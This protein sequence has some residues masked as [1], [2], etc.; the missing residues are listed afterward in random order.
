MRRTVAFRFLV[1]CAIVLVLYPQTAS[2]ARVLGIDVSTYQ[3][4]SIDW[5][6]VNSAGRVFAYARSSAGATIDDGTFAGNMSRGTDAGLL[7]GA[8]H[9][10]YPQYNS[11]QTEAAHFLAHSGS[12]IGPGYLR[13]V[14]D[15]EEAGGTVPVGASSLSAWVNAFISYVTANSPYGAQAEPLIYCNTNY[16]S[17]YLNSSVTSHDLWIANWNYSDAYAQNTANNPGTGVWGTAGINWSFWQYSDN[18]SVGGISPVDKD[19]ANGDINFVRSFLIGPPPPD[20]FERFDVNNTT[21][22]SGVANNGNYTWEAAKYSSTSAGTDAAAWNEGNFLRLAAGTDAGASNYTITANSNHTFAGMYLQTS[23]GGTVTVNGPGVLTTAS[24]DQGMYVDTSTQNLKI[25]AVIAGSSKLVWQGNGAGAGGSL[26]LLGD[27]TYTGGT[28]L[29]TGSGVNFNNDHSFGTGRITLGYT[30]GTATQFVMANDVATGPVT[31]ANAVTTKAGGT[32]VYVG[33]AAAPVTFSGNW[34]MPSGTSTLRIG[35]ASH[36]SSK[37]IISGV[38]SGSGG[39]L[40]KDG[41]G[42]LVLS[43]ANTYTGGTTITAGI[44]QLGDGGT[45]GKLST[46]GA[47]SNNGSL[48]FKQTDTVTQGTDFSGSAISGTGSLTQAGSGTLVL[49]AANTYNGKTIV[50][51]GTLSVSAEANLG[52]VPFSNVPDQLTINGGTFQA[53]AGFSISQTRGVTIGSSGATIRVLSGSLMAG[54]SITNTT[55]S[56]VTI[57]GGADFNPSGNNSTTFTNGK[58]YITGG[59][60]W[61]NGN[62]DNNSGAAPGSPVANFLTLDNGTYVNNGGHTLNA[63]K[64]ITLGPGGG[65]ID[66]TNGAMTYNGVITGAGALTKL[67]ANTLTLGGANIYA[68]GTNLNAGTITIAGASAKLG[69]GNVTVL[70]ATAGTSLVIQSGVTDAINNSALL[71]LAGGGTA[72]AADQG[73]ANLGAGINEI[74]GSLLL[75]GAAQAQ[76]LTYGS[77]S[78][79]A[80]VR[81]DEY[82]AGSGI[83]TVGL[84][85]DFNGDGSVDTR[86]FAAWRKSQ[87]TYGGSAGYDLWQSNF[88]R[89]SGSGSSGSLSQ[90]NVPEP[91]AMILGLLGVAA[92]AMLRSRRRNVS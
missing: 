53:T 60:R 79:A 61:L 23:G 67:S 38:M 90:T 47:I 2:A 4:G 62:N 74:I 17:N 84:P 25:N 31:L 8:Y 55:G 51:A 41:V 57:T 83:V 16:A 15:V 22:G 19:V 86:D 48:V 29:N 78:S 35:N 64:G 43:G 69:A 45:A 37:M 9:Y 28:A 33:P 50:N 7:M 18:G 88:G 75:G 77:M 14:L 56:T 42:T 58:W 87:D 36:T 72:G 24:G 66:T 70:G 5:D 63:N 10:S 85:G 91:G 76:G 39:A 34:T 73:Y 32:L 3:G 71:N 92:M 54:T 21:G 13:P 6:A 27:N 49:N 89:T 44:L 52:N 11:P 40:V 65:T 68:G 59:S 82:F 80:A 20:A 30:G 26:F 1:Y 81:S 12:Y 46:T